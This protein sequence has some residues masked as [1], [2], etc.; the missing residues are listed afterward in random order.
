[1]ASSIRRARDACSLLAAPL[2][3][4]TAAA[5]ALL[6]ACA[7]PAVA[8]ASAPGLDIRILV[9][10]TQPS[11]AA[12]AIAAEATRQAGVPVGYAA[13]VSTAWHA[14]VVHCADATVCDTAIAR[15]RRSG[16]YAEVEP[17]VR[18]QRAVM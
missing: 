13:S 6:T 17:D 8:A 10:L 7:V 4:A 9:K 11:G 12:A 14:L 1:M 3:V 5:L 15:L 16:S 18:K 2:A